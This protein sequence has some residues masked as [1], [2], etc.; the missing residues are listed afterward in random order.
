MIHALSRAAVLLALSGC[1]ASNFEK[2]SRL[3]RDVRLASNRESPGAQLSLWLAQAATQGSK[4][5]TLA[6]LRERTDLEGEK[7]P[8]LDFDRI[9]RDHPD[10]AALLKR[11]STAL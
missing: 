3:E 5:T 10:L 8:V 2:M 7:P 9:D 6:W 4:E 11:A 1:V